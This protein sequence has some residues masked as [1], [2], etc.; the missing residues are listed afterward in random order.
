MTLKLNYRETVTIVKVESD[1]YRNNKTVVDQA[2]VPAIFLQNTSFLDDNFQENVDA[3]AVCYPDFTNE[4]L[5]ENNYRLEGMYVLAPL[6]DVNSNDGWY[7]ITNVRINRNHLLATA[8][9]NIELLLKKST[10]I[11]G[12]S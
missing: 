6:F 3:D 2:I 7:K 12:V 11:M 9:D 4:F 5:I 8:I 1:G 10:R